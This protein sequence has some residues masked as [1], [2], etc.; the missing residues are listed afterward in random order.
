M[1][2]DGPKDA[3]DL[4]DLKKKIKEE[5]KKQLLEEIRS[6]LLMSEE[7]R[8][9]ITVRPDDELETEEISTQELVTTEPVRD[10]ETITISVT[11]ILKIASHSFKYANSRI[12]K[13]QWIEVIGL[14]A[15]KLDDNGLIVQIEDAYPMGHG[16]AVS[17]EIKDYKNYVRAFND[18]KKNNLFICGWYH[19]HPS[20]GL[21]MS[22]D[23]FDTQIRY[24]KL[25]PKSL[26]LVIDPYLIDGK[27]LG[28]KIFKADLKSRSWFEVPFD[29]KGQL[30]MRLLPELLEFINPISEGKA[31]YLE[32]DDD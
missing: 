4:E 3:L 18:I 10:K 20:Y 7:L 14:L 5:L 29:V 25:W 8:E 28:F 21:F 24:Q 12:P 9:E 32:Y 17:A 16:S 23:D 15:G 22:T 13:N 1:N 19:S 6:E 26:A 11:T 31:L 30:D 27:S 2:S